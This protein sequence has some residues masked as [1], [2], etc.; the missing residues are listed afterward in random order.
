MSDALRPAE[1]AFRALLAAPELY[2]AWAALCRQEWAAMQ[3][4]MHGLGREPENAAP[5]TSGGVRPGAP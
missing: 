2:A 5:P 3:P 1:Q 4:P